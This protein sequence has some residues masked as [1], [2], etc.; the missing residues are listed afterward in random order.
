MRGELHG[1]EVIAEESRAKRSGQTLSGDIFLPTLIQPF[2]KPHLLNESM[3]GMLSALGACLPLEETS[4]KAT[5]QIKRV[6]CRQ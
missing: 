4:Y 5:L 3:E 2:L 6:K 1:N